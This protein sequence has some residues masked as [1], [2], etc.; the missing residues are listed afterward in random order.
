MVV[1]NRKGDIGL[2]DSCGDTEAAATAGAEKNA[3][4]NL[5]SVKLGFFSTN[6]LVGGSPHTIENVTSGVYGNF[7]AILRP[8][9]CGTGIKGSVVAKYL[10][11][12][13]GIQDCYTVPTLVLHQHADFLFAVFK[14]LKNL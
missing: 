5:I 8:A 1:G 14:A 7:E 12:L 13:C 10:L 6:D 2:G 11:E 3:K 9:P 4:L